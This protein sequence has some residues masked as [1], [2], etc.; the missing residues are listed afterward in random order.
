VLV[1]SRPRRGAGS[2]RCAKVDPVNL[3]YLVMQPV[4]NASA[5]LSVQMFSLGIKSKPNGGID[6]LTKRLACR[7]VLLNHQ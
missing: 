2:K 7:A 1:A 4:L 5:K 6:G 3:A